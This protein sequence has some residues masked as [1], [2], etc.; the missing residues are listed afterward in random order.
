MPSFLPPCSIFQHSDGYFYITSGFDGQVARVNSEG[1]M[2]G[3][4]GS[5]G[6]ENGQLGEGHYVIVDADD[7]IYVTD[8]S[9]RPGLQVFA[10]T[11]PSP[12]P[13]R[14]FQFNRPPPAAPASP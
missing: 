4:L 2:S 14:R 13:V 8:V 3:A 9:K 11:G 10:R 5:P 1:I 7:N 6:S 12:D